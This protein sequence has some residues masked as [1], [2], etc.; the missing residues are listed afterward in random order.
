MLFV[1][2]HAP[3]A[4]QL[5]TFDELHDNVVLPLAGTPGGDAEIRTDGDVAP[6]TVTVARAT[7]PPPGPLHDN[8]KSFVFVSAAV[9]ADPLVGLLPDHP[10]EAVQ[11]VALELV[12]VNVELCPELTLLGFAVKET[13]GAGPSPPLCASSPPPDPPLPQPVKAIRRVN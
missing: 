2:D 11:E 8:V 3:D 4:L 9:G 5:V 13:D 10:P 6:P 12:Q 7:A 1:P